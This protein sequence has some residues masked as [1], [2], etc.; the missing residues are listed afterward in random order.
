MQ[1]RTVSF[2]SAL[3]VMTSNIGST[4]AVSGGRPM[5]FRYA[6]GGSQDAK[7]DAV[8]SVVTTELKVL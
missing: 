4:A 3:V 2:G 1:G 6:A 5:G 8:K 7:Y